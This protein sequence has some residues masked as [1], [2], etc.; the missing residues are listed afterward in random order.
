M[1]FFCGITY[2]HLYHNRNYLAKMATIR[3]N[4]ELKVHYQGMANAAFSKWKFGMK[5]YKRNHIL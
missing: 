2:F 3:V 4:M 5:C 1:W